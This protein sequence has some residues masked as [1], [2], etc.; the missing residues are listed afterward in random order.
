MNAFRV[1]K[2]LLNQELERKK[3]KQS[4]LK[5]RIERIEAEIQLL[6][7]KYELG[8]IKKYESLN[9]YAMNHAYLRSIVK[10]R[11]ELEGKFECLLQELDHLR[12]EISL[13]NGEIK[14]IEKAMK[15]L[16]KLKFLKQRVVEDRGSH[17]VFVRKF[18]SSNFDV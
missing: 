7:K 5:L 12:E 18:Y 9:L 15:R 17:E 3:L 13:L 8:K 14:A 11:K 4:E 1:Y 10:S 16:E 2:K 6:R